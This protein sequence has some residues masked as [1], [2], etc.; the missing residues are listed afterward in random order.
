MIDGLKLTMGGEELRTLL[1]ARVAEHRASAER[2][3]GEA[4]RTPEEQ[5]D[6]H[7]LLPEHMC[8]NEAE[9]HEWRTD[10]LEFIHEHL[11][12]L[13]TYRLSESDL[14]FAELLPPK[15]GFL[16][17]AEYEERTSVGF[18]IRPFR[19]RPS[20]SGGCAGRMIRPMRTAAGSAASTTFRTCHGA[21]RTVLRRTSSPS[22]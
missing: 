17:Q 3:H 21:S 14:A 19:S 12:P 4:R 1:K 2:W 8:E 20:A 6:D 16:E 18:S 9:R 10:V 22:S 13:E 7:P 11:E 5:T 15:P